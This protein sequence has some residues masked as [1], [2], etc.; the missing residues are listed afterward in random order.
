M[1]LSFII[2]NRNTKDLLMDCLDS[3]YRTVRQSEFEIWVVDN[4]SSDDSVTAAKERFPDVR[5]IENRENLGFARA[6]NQA[7]G[8][9]RGDYAV[10]LNSD[11]VLTEGAIDTMV[12]FMEVNKEIGICG[13]QLLNRD[14]SRQNSISN[15]PTL[16]TELLNKSLLRRLFPQKY[17]GKEQTFSAPV[18]VETVIGAC[19][20]V[21]RKAMDDAGLMDEAYFFFLEET[22]WC[23]QM[24]KRGWKVFHHPLARI[25]H[26]QGQTAKKVPVRARIEYWRSRYVFFEKNYGTRASGVLRAGLFI[27]LSVDLFLAFLLSLATLFSYK[28]A[29]DKLRLYSGILSWHLRRF[30]EGDGLRGRQ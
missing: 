11:A 23:L 27:K 4:G 7:L 26:L 22:D 1:N 9:M 14:G 15:I 20:V 8:K 25:Y 2:I 3:V 24:R 13:G 16:A 28:R 12:A 30:P 6:N 19:M 21:R 17:P 10:L 29:V 5:I 18:E